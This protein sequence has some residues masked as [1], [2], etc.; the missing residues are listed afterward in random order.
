MKIIAQK[1]T[2]VN[3]KATKQAAQKQ[4]KAKT[5]RVYIYFNTVLPQSYFVELTN[6]FFVV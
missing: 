4:M 2:S 1:A 3:E 5:N 6:C